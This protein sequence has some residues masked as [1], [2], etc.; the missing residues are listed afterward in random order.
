MTW[1]E[2]KTRVEQMLAEVEEYV[3]T[4]HKAGLPD[5][6]RWELDAEALRLL[7]SHAI[8]CED[9][10]REVKLGVIEFHSER[11]NP[12][13]CRRF[14]AVMDDLRASGSI[15]DVWLMDIATV[16]G[17]FGYQMRVFSTAKSEASAV[18]GQ[19]LPSPP[20]TV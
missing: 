6:D 2:A 19:H 20:E 4:Q 10:L 15:V 1:D 17:E 3:I 8:P 9:T 13:L 5:D 7:L 18:T 11:L 12:G 16:L 14:Y